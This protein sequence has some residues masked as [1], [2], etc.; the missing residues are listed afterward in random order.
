M[1]RNSQPKLILEFNGL[2]G[3]GKSTISSELESLFNN[4]GISSIRSY[5]SKGFHRNNKTLFLN[6]KWCY[7]IICLF[8]F[9]MKVYPRKDRKSGVIA[10]VSYLRMYTDYLRAAQ[11]TILIADEG[12]VQAITSFFHL[13][14]ISSHRQIERF[15]SFI[16]KD[17]IEFI[18]VDCQNEI[19]IAFSR[20]KGRGETGARLDVMEGKELM[21]ALV[22][23]SDNLRLIRDIFS[24]ALYQRV[25]HID[26]KLSPAFNASVIYN[27]LSLYINSNEV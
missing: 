5:Y 19:D 12:L 6:P 1:G 26:T 22:V 14:A 20:I 13:D 7:V 16:K 18:R 3:S 23:Q 2:P 17:K 4:N 24:N 9:A 25:I 11:D 27:E 15:L 8:F 10:F 21:E